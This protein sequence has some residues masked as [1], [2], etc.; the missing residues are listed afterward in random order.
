[1]NLKYTMLLLASVLTVTSL[2]A[3]QDLQGQSQANTSKV[4]QSTPQEHS[5]SKEEAIAKCLWITNQEEVMISRFA[6]DKAKDEAV[7]A[8]AATLEKSHQES[9]DELKALTTKLAAGQHAT[10]KGSSGSAKDTSVVDFVQMHQEVSD[11][12]LKDSK[13]MLNSKSGAEFDACFVG[14]QI[15]KHAMMHSSFTVLQRHT[16]GEL[17]AFLKDRLATNAEHMQAATNLMEK[18]S[19]KSVTKTAKKSE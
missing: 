6:K 9:M 5:R 1:M 4:K 15:A 7:R 18:L 19:D 13:E 14:M 2:D 12:C 16:S 17:Q 3:Q 8:L 11:Q 10:E